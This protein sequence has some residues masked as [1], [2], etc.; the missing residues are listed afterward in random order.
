M[1]L[2]IAANSTIRVCVSSML[3]LSADYLSYRDLL[4]MER[5]SALVQC[6]FLWGFAYVLEL[7][8]AMV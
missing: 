8:V 1:Y 5:L 4:E 2:W 6:V 7:A 3:L